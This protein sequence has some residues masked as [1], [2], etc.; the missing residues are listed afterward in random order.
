[1]FAPYRQMDVQFPHVVPQVPRKSLRCFFGFHKLHAFTISYNPRYICVGMNIGFYCVCG[2]KIGNVEQ[3][4]SRPFT[5]GVG[6]NWDGMGG[7][8]G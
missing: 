7:N 2:K 4:S 5:I 1:M 3:P 8:D 6:A